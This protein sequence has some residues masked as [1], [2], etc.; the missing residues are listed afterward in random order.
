MR[1]YVAGPLSGD[2][3]VNVRRNV[4]RAMVIGGHLVERGHTP[5]VPHLQELM[6]RAWVDAG[7]E[8]FDYER[9]LE[10]D[11]EWIRQ[12]EALFKIAASP[13]ADRE[14]AYAISRG[15]PVYRRL[16]DVPVP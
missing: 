12:C 1:I 11:F 14:E 7:H 8:A 13:G 9:W 15:L 3:R 5:F 2:T 4:E 6:E 10:M 16:D